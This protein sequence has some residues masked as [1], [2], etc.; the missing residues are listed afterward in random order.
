MKSRFAWA[1]AL[2]VVAASYWI[3]L[4]VATH[5]PRELKIGGKDKFLHFSAFAIL[6]LLVALSVNRWR[7]LTLTVTAAIIITLA[8]YGALDEYLQGVLTTQRTPDVKDWVMDVAGAT[9]GSAVAWGITRVFHK[10]PAG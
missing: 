7:R 5:I 9:V 6:G 8:V 10:S 1:A 2:P 4:F 3:A